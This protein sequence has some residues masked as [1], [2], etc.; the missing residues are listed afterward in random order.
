[1]GE[2]RRLVFLM[3]DTQGADCVG[4]YGRP[5]LHTPN[6]DALASG[7]IRFDR[8]YTTCPL[9][10]PARGALFT[11]RHPAEN[12]AWAN[13]LTPRADVRHMGQYLRR[14]GIA[15]AYTGKWHLDGTDYFDSG[16]CP[17]GWVPECWYDGRNYL[18]DLPRSLRAFSRQYHTRAE[19]ED[20]GFGED[21]TFASRVANKAIDFLKA[22]EDE[23]FLL[24]VSWDEPHH[25][26]IAPPPFTD[27]F[28]DY[29][30]DQGPGRDD[31][32]REKPE[33][34]KAWAERVRRHGQQHMAANGHYR[35]PQYFA[36]NAFVDSQLGRVMDA[37]DRYAPDALVIHTSDHGEMKYSHGLASKGPAMYDEITRIP[38]IVRQPGRIGPGQIDRSPLSHIDVMPTVLDYFGIAVPRSLPGRSLL[39]RFADPTGAEKHPAFIQYQRFSKNI[40]GDLI[41]I[42][43][44][45]NGRYKLVLNLFQTDE[46][47]DLEEDPAE[48][49]NLIGRPELREKAQELH[50]LVVD[51]MIRTFDPFFG[52]NWIRRH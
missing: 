9:C 25:P 16:V 50:S 37:V 29:E 18:E 4:C 48:L 31:D 23:D 7:G 3:T 34:Q 1:M 46:L 12:G 11:G 39:S 26:S 47:Y 13:E 40:H 36:C 38:F 15:A 27:M 8:A 43:A 2:K 41:P 19:L 45:F 24:V 33:H 5:E 49:R 51:E 21:M 42:R 20:A 14:G 17:E 10:T 28:L 30:F 32:L 44:V 6:I 52:V 35:C 22:H